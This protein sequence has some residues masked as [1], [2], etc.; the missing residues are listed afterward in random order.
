VQESDEIGLP[1]SLRVARAFYKA[2][3]RATRWPENPINGR[4]LIVADLRRPALA[5]G[6]QQVSCG[7]FR[8]GPLSCL[9]EVVRSGWGIEKGPVP[10]EGWTRHNCDMAE[11]DCT[12]YSV[13]VKNRGTPPNPWKW[14]IYRAGRSSPVKQS[15]VSF[16]TMA[17]ASKAGKEALRLLLEKLD[18]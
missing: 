1:R 13:V 9:P 16:Q 10:S 11:F 6:L 17:K 2:P 18:S 12:D 8:A 14:E 5:A 3:T 15:S 4:P 7:E